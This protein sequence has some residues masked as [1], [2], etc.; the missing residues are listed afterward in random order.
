ML[1]AEENNIW[2]IKN[3]GLTQRIK[4]CEAVKRYFTMSLLMH[5][6]IIIW[7]LKKLFIVRLIWII[8][9]DVACQVDGLSMGL[10]LEDGTQ[11]YWS[12][13]EE[14]QYAMLK[15]GSTPTHFCARQHCLVQPLSSTH[16]KIL[17]HLYAEPTILNLLM[18]FLS[19]M[20][21]VCD[22]KR[23]NNWYEGFGS[24]DSICGSKWV[25]L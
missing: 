10:R 1:A 14:F 25:G 7:L 3:M 4:V 20:C 6:E 2:T 11:K 16:A 15:C 17:K 18:F 5:N 9:L 12:T 22:V 24:F 8:S 19:V 23:M 21:M 13:H